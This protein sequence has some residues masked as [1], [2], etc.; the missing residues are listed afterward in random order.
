MW[1]EQEHFWFQIIEKY[2]LQRLGS[3]CRILLLS[4]VLNLRNFPS[5]LRPRSYGLCMMTADLSPP[6]GQDCSMLKKLLRFEMTLQLLNFW[7]QRLHLKR[8][9]GFY[10]WYNKKNC[11]KHQFFSYKMFI[12][13][14]CFS[15]YHCIVWTFQWNFETLPNLW[16]RPETRYNAQL[17]QIFSIKCTIIYSKHKYLEPITICDAN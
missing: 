9:Y 4:A 12:L 14:T 11:F 7:R 6:A 16:I 3:T 15:S 5:S 8:L 10:F 2:L 1:S 13:A 17:P